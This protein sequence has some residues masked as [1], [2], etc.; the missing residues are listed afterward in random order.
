MLNSILDVARQE[1]KKEENKQ[2]L[3]DVLDP[4]VCTYKYLFYI[5]FI[6]LLLIFIINTFTLYLFIKNYKK[7][8]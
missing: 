4:L 3:F 6:L 2:I 1:L 7:S 5:I 8:L